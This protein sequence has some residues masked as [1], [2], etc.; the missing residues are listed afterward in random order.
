MKKHAGFAGSSF[1]LK[2]TAACSNSSPQKTY[3]VEGLNV[4]LR[5]AVVLGCRMMVAA[6]AQK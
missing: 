3:K 4:G 5:S 2:T 1:R 6:A